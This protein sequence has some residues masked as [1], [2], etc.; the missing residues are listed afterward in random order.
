MLKRNKKEQII[1]VTGSLPKVS[2]NTDK[3]RLNAIKK[4]HLNECEN[5][6]LYELL[7]SK[8]KIANWT[9]RDYNISD[10]SFVSDIIIEDKDKN[11][12]KFTFSCSPF[13]SKQIENSDIGGVTMLIDTLY[14]KHNASDSIKLEEDQAEQFFKNVVK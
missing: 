2:F 5:I 9:V 11:V 14:T 3:D 12:Y 7:S 10:N 13:D 6:T 8:Y 4:A 1:L